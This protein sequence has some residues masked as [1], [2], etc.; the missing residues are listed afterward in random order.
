MILETWLKIEENGK[1]VRQNIVED[2]IREISVKEN[3]VRG[4]T[5]TD[6]RTTV[7]HDLNEPMIYAMYLMNDEGKTLKTLKRQN[8]DVIETR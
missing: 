6:E 7:I 5:R 1:I 2:N 4:I 8:Q 3:M